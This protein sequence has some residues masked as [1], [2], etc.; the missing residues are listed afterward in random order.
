MPAAIVVAATVTGASAAIGTAVVGAITTA[1]ISTA[2]AT[3]VG[4][5]IISGAIT[6]A[7]G[8]S[9]SDVLKS[10]VIGGTVSF[11]GGQASSQISG[12]V[13]EATGLSVQASNVVAGATVGAGISSLAD[14]DP[15]AGAIAGTVG[16]IGSTTYATEIGTALGAEGAAAPIIGNAVIN[17]ALSG[18]AASVTGAN[19]EKSMLSGA[20]RGAAMASTTDFSEAVLGTENIKDISEATGL[21]KG[22][23]ESIFTTS[24]AN[25]VTAEISGQG[26]LLET[27]GISLVAQGVGA[28]SANLMQSAMKDVLDKDPEIMT[29]VLTA[30][31]GI[32]TTATNAALRGE[33]VQKALEN[34][35][36]GI[37]LSSVQTYQAEAD[38]QD[39][40][41][42]QREKDIVASQQE[43]PPLQV[44]GDGVGFETG[45]D[46]IE[47]LK[48]EA[49]SGI[50][51]EVI[52]SEVVEDEG[53]TYEVKLVQGVRDDGSLY[54]YKIIVDQDGSVSYEWNPS[55]SESVASRERPDLRSSPPE[56]AVPSDRVNLFGTTQE[57][58][59]PVAVPD[60]PPIVVGIDL[61]K[62][63]DPSLGGGDA[64]IRSTQGPTGFTETAGIFQFIGTEPTSGLQKYK[65][66]NQSFTLIMLPNKQPA[67][68]HDVV[69]FVLIPKEEPSSD[70]TQPPKLT[71]DERRLEDFTPPP[72]DV[73]PPEPTKLPPRTAANRDEGA[74]GTAGEKGAAGGLTGLEEQRRKER[75]AT[76]SRIV[77]E[78]LSRL[79]A[80]LTQAES[81]AQQTSI[82]LQR[83]QAQQRKFT[84]PNFVAISGPDL[85]SSLEQETQFATDAVERAEDARAAAAE[86]LV[87]IDALQRGEQTLTDEQILGYLRTG[88]LPP[89]GGEG[90]GEPGTR[91]PG[92]G[93]D[94][95]GTGTGSLDRGDGTGAGDRGT[96]PGAGGEGLGLG[97]GGT[98]GEGS[99]ELTT[100]LSPS[101]IFDS[102]TGGRPE[103]TPFSSRVTGEAL[104]GILGAKEPLFG[105]D[106]DEQRAVWNRRS[107]RLR[108]A[109]GL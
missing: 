2:V 57:D 32:A 62:Y 93:A 15:L 17:S 97:G 56:T 73:P 25:G 28:K 63:G 53:L 96:G 76:I 47:T 14:G 61:R 43:Q 77:E 55:F 106:P 86:G 3:A 54:E 11:V 90:D 36:P 68:L 8:G 82:N 98:G 19:V 22:Q 48:R 78:E 91:G 95:E 1:T 65:V 45:L 99:G 37:I 75:D 34:N 35:A 24:V 58:L 70:P 92:T 85:A 21:S 30:T 18:I 4:S 83:A 71:F 101:L 40:L 60:A 29:S 49:L 31:G 109:L 9:T 87:N 41:A 94:E 100:R 13:S 69:D 80:Q 27:V 74:S 84:A 6:A 38:R 104:A 79:T 72:E 42:A 51:E 89:A 5:G 16:A 33:D 102:E 81:E 20:V 39:A 66:G 107:L 105:G 103:T 23:V 52:R 10:A 67:L 50:G 88:Q 7:Q 44:A 108:R 64:L 59:R 26:E 46:L 12:A